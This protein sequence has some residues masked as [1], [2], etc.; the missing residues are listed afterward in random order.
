MLSVSDIRKRP[1]GIRFEREYD[2]KEA[3][4]MRDPQV[5]DIKNVRA[6]GRAQFDDGLY[7]LEY[8]L[9]YQITLPSS[10]SMTPVVLDE[11]QTV[12]ELFI[13]EA[14]VASKQE[15]VDENLVLV[16]SE[17]QLD[18]EESIIDNI[19]LAIPLQVLTETEKESQTLPTGEDWA[20]L[21]EEQYQA[22]QKEKAK[23]NSPFAG[24]QGL[25]D[26]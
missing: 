18:L 15:M 21:T 23:D 5:I 25:F 16:L 22:Q 3:L 17:G 14:D 8:Q 9:G 20:V 26:E 7:L 13:E 2:V 19:L 12:Q 1:E 6:S 10:R 11:M 24:L 4:L